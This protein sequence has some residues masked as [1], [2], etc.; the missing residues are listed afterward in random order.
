MKDDLKRLVNEFLEETK[1]AR[2]E[3]IEQQ[4]TNESPIF[5]EK[6]LHPPTFQH[7]IWWLNEQD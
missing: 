7:F 4:H 6:V 1:Q 3:I 2:T 5:K